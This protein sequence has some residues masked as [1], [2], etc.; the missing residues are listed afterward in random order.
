MSNDREHRSA[1]VA[2]IL[3]A[4]DEIELLR[5][6]ILFLEARGYRI[7]AVASGVDAIDEVTANAA[8]F[9]LVF[10]DENMPG[11]SG[12]DTLDRIK[13]VAP[14]LP[15]VLITKSEDEEIMDLAV[16]NRIADYLIKPV[17]PSQILLSIKKTLHSDRLISETD[18]RRSR[19]RYLDME[20]R[21]AS[22][23]TISRWHEVYT[24][25][26]ADTVALSG[27]N[28]DTASII[29]S[30]A[31]TAEDAFFR[32]VRKNYLSW[33]RRRDTGS[34]PLMSPDILDRSVLPLMRRDGRPVLMLLDNLSLAQWM[35]AK[36]VFTSRFDIAGEELYTAILPTS[37]QYCRNAIMS[38]MMPADTARR[39]PALWV[40]ESDPAGKNAAEETL[41]RDWLARRHLAGCPMTYHRTTDTASMRALARDLRGNASADA[42]TVIIVS[43]T[44]MLSH[45]MADNAM[46][47]EIAPD[48]SAF[49]SVFLSWLRHS[50]L[51]ELLD[52]IA[53]NGRQLIVT[54]DH[55]AVKVDN[56]VRVTAGADAT[57][58]LRHKF[59]RNITAPDR[60][61]L[62]IRNPEEA[63]IPAP[64]MASSLILAGRRDFLLYPNNFSRFARSFAGSYQ[65]GGISM[66]EMLLP[67]ITLTPK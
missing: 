67:L 13:A 48:D 9:D 61:V 5:S 46:L 29:S 57:N 8:A 23:D 49:R 1:P 41:L 50:P 15:V 28:S 37:T 2:R 58:A 60:H 33:I 26:T 36:T 17:N 39:F 42:L 59:G 54:T 53:D 52:S 21:I 31:G 44:D 19:E 20:A 65:H 34:Q 56:P 47:R 55:G 24:Q 45:A 40:G 64:S 6:H 4:D 16:G 25:L 66:H 51:C 12:L 11:I 14:A 27:G 43:F 35:V 30:L 32:F 63:G 22:A 38:G 10:L 3:W 18:S 62:Q 7:T